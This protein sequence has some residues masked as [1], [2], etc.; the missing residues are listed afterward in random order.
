MPDTIDGDDDEDGVPDASDL[1]PGT[2]NGTNIA[3]DGC[4]DLDHDGISDSNDSCAG[5]PT[6]GW[7][8]SSETDHDSD[9]CADDGIDPDDDNDGVADGSDDCPTG[10]LGWTASASTDYDG[11]G[12]QDSGEDGDDDNDGVGDAD[13]DCQTG[14]TGWSSS[15]TTVTTPTA[16]GTAPPRTGTMT[17]TA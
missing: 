5:L 14:F 3:S 8:S 9:G 11:D 12:C 10:D 4:S 16:A 15:A 6:D 2:A 13:D 7:A 1:C 17:T